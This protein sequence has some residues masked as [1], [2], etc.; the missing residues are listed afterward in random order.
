MADLAAMR[1]AFGRLGFSAAAA[2]AIVNEQ[3]IDSVKEL[4]LLSDKEVENLCKVVRAP[5]GPSLIPMQD[6]QEHREYCQTQAYP[7]H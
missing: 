4:Q 5:A 1:M 7:S 3:A 2:A 6:K